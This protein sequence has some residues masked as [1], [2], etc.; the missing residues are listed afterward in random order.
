MGDARA[1]CA[2]CGGASKY[3]CPACERASCSLE[4][5]RAHKVAHAC[6]GKRARDGFVRLDAFTDRDV[7][8]D[9]RFLEDVG[10]MRERA[11]RWA[12]TGGGGGTGGA[13]DARSDG[14]DGGRGGRERAGGKRVGRDGRDGVLES[15]RAACAARGVE[16]RFVSEGMERRRKNTTRFNRRGGDVSWRLEWAF[17]VEGER[18][19]RIDENVRDDAMM[20]DVY[21][22]HVR[23]MTLAVENKASMA[24]FKPAAFDAAGGFRIFMEKF[25]TPANAKLWH[26]V[27]LEDTVATALRGKTVLEFPT[28]HVV[29]TSLAKTYALAPATDASDLHPE[30]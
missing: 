5:A 10:A 24:T 19:V 13:R 25:D 9:Y 2:T 1:S 29:P 30:P 22:A 15:L 17:H 7:Q 21:A 6:S 26:A 12:R 11:A 20:G 18:V 3:R 4:C 28:F 27:R 8:R 14:R 23:E 16:V